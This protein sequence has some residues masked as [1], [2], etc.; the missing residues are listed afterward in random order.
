M[1]SASVRPMLCLNAIANVSLVA[2]PVQLVF[3]GV[4]VTGC[5]SLNAPL[6]SVVADAVSAASPAVEVTVAVLEAV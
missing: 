6:A 1:R 5:A 2:G 3:A 4:I